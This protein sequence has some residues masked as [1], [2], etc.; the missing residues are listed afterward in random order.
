MSSLLSRVLVGPFIAVCAGCSGMPA[1]P[2]SPTP[3]TGVP[4]TEIPNLA[5]EYTITFLAKDCEAAYPSEARIRTYSSRLDQKEAAVNLVLTGLPDVFSIG[6]PTLRGIIESPSL[7]TMTGYIGNDQ[8]EGIFEPITSANLLSILVD[9]LTLTPS[10]QGFAGTFSGAFL[11]YDRSGVGW[12]TIGS[13]CLSQR[14]AV[15]LTH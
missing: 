14:H 13:K 7:L 8:W 2:T 5:G 1:G 4:V 9:N 12:S 10:S 11:L 6:N 3:S 15:T